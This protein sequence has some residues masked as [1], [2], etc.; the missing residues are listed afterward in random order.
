[1]FQEAKAEAQ[2]S[3]C[4][5][6]VVGGCAFG[7][8]VEA[9]QQH[10][11]LLLGGSG[12]VERFVEG[13]FLPGHRGADLKGDEWLFRREG[14]GPDRFAGLGRGLEIDDDA[15]PSA[16][17]DGV[18]DDRVGGHGLA[19]AG[20]SNDDS[21][22][23]LIGGALHDLAGA[24]PLPRQRVPFD[25]AESDV[26]AGWGRTSASCEHLRFHAGFCSF[27]IPWRP[28]CRRSRARRGR[29]AW[30]VRGSATLFWALGGTS[31]GTGRC[32]RR[33]RVRAVRR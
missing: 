27:P 14:G 11:C 30:I 3:L 2:P 20:G 12:P 1:M 21:M 23:E 6:G 32:L 28:G 9:R 13:G 24:I 17:D 33:V 29:P 19:G 16:S 10:G 25:V 8:H 5:A 7:C 22:A 31:P 4:D 18:V 15:S 26:E